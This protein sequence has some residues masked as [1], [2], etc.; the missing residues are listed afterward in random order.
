M[1]Y[2]RLFLIPSPLGEGAIDW[3]IPSHVKQ[4]IANLTYFV[5]EHPKTARH[6]LKQIALQRPIQAIT[7]QTLDKHTP[8]NELDSLLGPIYAGN[9]MGLLS[10]AG[11]PAIADPGANL[12]RIAHE[13]QIQ[14][15]P[16]VGPSSILL[17]LMASGLNGQCFSFHGYLPID[18]VS[19]AKKIIQ[20]ESESFKFNQTQIFIETPYRNKKLFELL[21]MH[22]Q[23]STHLCIASNLTLQDEG[24][25]TKTI[26]DWQ[27]NLPDFEKKPTVFLLH[28]YQT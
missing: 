10:E 11:C 25:N 2:G 22:C 6:F 17:A 23:G 26:K 19:C 1:Q 12:V 20:M 13:K 16:L 4:C 14:V 18:K 9:D 28:R 15:V 24:I 27:T 3:I 21:A 5:V 7:L 8:I